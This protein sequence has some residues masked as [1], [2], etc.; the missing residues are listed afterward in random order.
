M[1]I[2]QSL[3]HLRHSAAHL[4]NQA[5]HELFPDAKPTIGPATETG[6]FYDFQPSHNFTLKDLPIIEERMRDIAKRNYS[7]T[8]KQV[9]KEEARHMFENNPFKLELIDAI[10]NETVG[11]YWQ[12]PDFYDLCKGGHVA[13]LGEV[14][15]F[16]LTGISGSYWRAD[17]NGIPLQRI[18]GVAFL[19]QE[20]MDNYFAAIEEAKRYDHRTLGQQLDLFSFHEEAPGSVFFHDKGVKLFNTLVAYSRFMQQDDYQE[21]RTPLVNNQSLYVTSGHYDNYK[22]NAFTLTVDD[23]DYWIRPMN[24]PSCA[25]VFSEKPHSYRE[26]PMRIAEYGMCHRY[27]LSGVLHGL[28]RVRTFTQDDA[29]IFC[30][31]SQIEDEVIK[32]LNLTRTIYNKFGFS[33]IKMAL[34]TRPE[35]S[36]GSL[37]LWEKATTALSNA[38]N[39]CGLTFVIQEGEGA[40]YGPKIEMKIEDRMGREWQCGTI[41]V[42]FNIPQRFNLEYIQSDQSK[43]APVMIHRAIYGSIERFLGII[44]EHFKGQFPFWL[45]P[46]QIRIL[47]ITDEQKEYAQTIHQQL[48]KAGIRVTI[49]T[50]SDQISA[51]IKNAQVMYVPWMI[52]IGK[53]EVA[54]NSVALRYLDGKQEFGLSI[55][56]VITKARELTLF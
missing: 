20:E 44:T 18:S 19:T 17:R 48:K 51:Q 23:A 54:H 3:E 29:H 46:E 24:C 10:P 26:L 38:L 13:N 7:I 40:F 21:I 53:K 35:K 1:A 37:E 8:G 47:T 34:S 42:D 4:L 55:E 49:D 33:A 36:I 56:Q 31:A 25:L 28:F 30:T 32:V 11:I 43:A 41:Q 5:V 39:A 16:K 52:V 22:E 12:G 14:V 9:T 45:A 50:S 27:E 6:F 2:S 15:H